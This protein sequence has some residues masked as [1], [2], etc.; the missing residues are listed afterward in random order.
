MTYVGEHPILD[1]KERFHRRWAHSGETLAKMRAN[2]KRR[3]EEAAAAWPPK[4]IL[5]AI[6]KQFQAVRSGEPYHFDV[7]LVT[8]ARRRFG[9]WDDG[10]SPSRADL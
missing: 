2:A 4:R 9:S 10:H 3:S 6:R 1:Y 5:L 8:A 7:E